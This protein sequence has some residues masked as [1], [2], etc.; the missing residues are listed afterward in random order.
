MTESRTHA[1]NQQVRSPYESLTQR[2]SDSPDAGRAP[3]WRTTTYIPFPK[4]NIISYQ[5]QMQYPVNLGYRAH[6]WTRCPVWYK[7]GLVQGRAAARA[8]PPEK[9]MWKDY[10][11]PVFCCFAKKDGYQEI[12]VETAEELTQ[13]IQELYTLYDRINEQVKLLET[14]CL[15]LNCATK[16]PHLWFYKELGFIKE[17]FCAILRFQRVQIIII[18][19]YCT[20]DYTRDYTRDVIKST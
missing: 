10:I 3:V 13:R 4:S 20:R 7:L 14:Y 9:G 19:L 16:E 8:P 11:A 2:F 18:K 15:L 12:G 5:A 6:S 17:A 1:T